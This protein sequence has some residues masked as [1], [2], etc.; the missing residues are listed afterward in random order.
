M[1]QRAVDPQR[2]QERA[3]KLFALARDQ[4]GTPEGEAAARFA[5]QLLREQS[6]NLAGLDR[7]A[8]DAADPFVRQ[9]ILLGGPRMWRCRLLTL[10]SRHCECVGAYRSGQGRGSLYGRRSN[11][12]VAE[13][14]F[15][16]LSRTM[17]LERALLLGSHQGEGEVELARRANDFTMSALLA[18]ELRLAELRDEEGAGMSTALVRQSRRGLYAWM[19]AHGH[20]LKRE[21]PFGY[22][23]DAAGYQAGYRLPLQKAVGPE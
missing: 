3:R 8:L 12:Q 13:H 19:Q 17:T 23:W 16:V 9:E 18:L 11:V 21:V 20:S 5:R 2:H 6:L 1:T 4:Q 22:S 7:E 15:M 10:V 14:L